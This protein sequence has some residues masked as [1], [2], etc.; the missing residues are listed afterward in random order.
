MAREIETVVVIGGG[1]MGSGI[2]GLCAERGKKVLLLEI[3]QDAAKKAMDRIKNG[4][5]P[6]VDTPEKANNITLGTIDDDLVK[7]ADYD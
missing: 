4:R 7:I 3:S 2:A 6:A 5:P 1:T